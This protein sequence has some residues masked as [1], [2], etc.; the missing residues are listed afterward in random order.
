MKVSVVTVCLNSERTIGYTIQSFLDQI[1]PDKEMLIIDGGSRDN[2]MAIANS[3][4]SG[5]LRIWS[6]SDRGIYDAMN[7]G[8]QLYGGDAVGFLNSDDTFH[9]SSALESIAHGLGGGD[10]VYGDLIFVRDHRSKRIL[11]TWKAGQYHRRSFRFGWLPPHPTFY[12][13]RSLAERVGGF[14]L[15]YGTAAD[16]D[17]MLRAMQLHDPGICYV[18][19]I[20]VDFQHGGRSTGTIGGYIAANLNCL[21]SRRRHLKSPP[22]DIALF[23]KPL[24][25][26]HQFRWAG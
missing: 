13:R 25:K 2:T 14:D 20:L 26:L 19:R 6:E 7:K 16:Y 8:L 3:F 15:D 10:L 18:P 9:D 23:A 4:A 24:R 5:Q 22:V 17:F 11:R 1:W 21:K 12:I